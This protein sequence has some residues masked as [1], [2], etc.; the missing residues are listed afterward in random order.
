MLDDYAAYETGNHHAAHERNRAHYGEW[1]DVFD[2]NAHGPGYVTPTAR[3]R[4]NKVALLMEQKSEIHFHTFTVESYRALLR[5]F[6]DTM[7]RTLGVLEVVEN[8]VEVIAVLKKS[9]I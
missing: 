6:C 4:E 7:D 5:H 2:R 3:E 9:S 1:V 8:G